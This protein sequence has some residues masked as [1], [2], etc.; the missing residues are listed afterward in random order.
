MGNYR[1]YLCNAEFIFLRGLRKHYQNEKCPRVTKEMKEAMLKPFFRVLIEV[2]EVVPTRLIKPEQFLHSY[3][4]E[5]CSPNYKEKLLEVAK[6]IGVS[7]ESKQH[8][9]L[10]Q[11]SKGDKN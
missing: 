9:P 3:N 7:L 4:I 2:S 10:S 1:C 11:K 5:T 6:E 8:V